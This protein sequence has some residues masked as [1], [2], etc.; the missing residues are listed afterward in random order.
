MIIDDNTTLVQENGD[1]MG[2]FIDIDVYDKVPEG[3]LKHIDLFFCKRLLTI[4][5]GK[6]E[7]ISFKN[8]IRNLCLDTILSNRR[9]YLMLFQRVTEI[10]GKHAKRYTYRELFGAYYGINMI[11]YSPS[12]FE[13]Y[14]FIEFEG[15]TAMIVRDYIKYLETRYSRTDFREPKEK[16]ITPH[17]KYINFNLPY[18]KY[19]NN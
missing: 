7:D 18:R 16:Q 6:K 13:N 1:V 14:S 19:L 10:L 3:F 11:P 2:V 17:Y 5:S 12:I 15:R 9:K 4:K 8:R